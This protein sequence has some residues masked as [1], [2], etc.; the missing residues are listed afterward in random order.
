MA[1]SGITK[2]ALADAL[3][4]QLEEE[5][6]AKISVGDICARCDMN[7]NSFYYHFKDK[8]ELV[9]WIFDTEFLEAVA[10]QPSGE[11]KAFMQLLLHYLYEN[12]DFY[13]K[14]LKVQGANSFSEHFH[15]ILAQL[16]EAHMKDLIAVQ[17]EELSDQI[18]AQVV[19]QFHLTFVTDGIVCAVERWLMDKNGIDDQQ[20]MML[21]ESC[22]RKMATWVY[23]RI[24]PEG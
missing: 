18:P 13:R 3:K 14:M 2:R 10:Q 7:R 23:H 5:P 12:R 17:M 20:F 22:F 9:N 15:E 4:A 19:H 1:D 24:N 21:V 6:F 16:V 11:Y 8:F